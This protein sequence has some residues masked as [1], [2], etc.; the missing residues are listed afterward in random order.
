MYKLIR[1]LLFL[2]DAEAIHEFSTK[3]IKFFNLIP[4]SS[5]MMRKYYLVS[6][7]SLEREVFG[8]KFKNPVGLAAGFDKNAEYYDEFSN[9]GFGFIEIGTVTP[10]PQPGNPKKRIFRLVEN[11]SM[12]NRLGFNNK[13]LKEVA[14]NLK[15]ERDIIV[16][17]NIGKNS[18]TD[19]KEGYKD[20]LKC[21]SS[22]YDYV[23]Y[24]AVNI[25]SPN[26]KDLRKLHNKDLLKPLL[27][28]LVEYN[29]RQ[30]KK[31]PIL[32]KISPDLTNNQLN[33]IIS[34]I[35]DLEIDGV[36]ATNTSI[37]REGI[38]SVY[39]N[40]KGGLSGKLLNKKSNEIIRYL[41]ENLAKDFPIIGVGGIM[42]PEDAI[43]KINCGADLIQIYTGF[44]YQGPSLIKKINKLLLK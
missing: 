40:E 34:I 4:L 35:L 13:G 5:L 24:F 23:D 15:K 9:F 14:N 1:N 41:R 26:T 12:I 18:F 31:K 37:S 38:T 2:F 17:A 10:L 29:Q 28:K 27:Q 8:I 36:I 16:G 39:K 33:D 21:L 3:S 44:I 7:K 6:D 20:Y 42:S 30:N 25:S 43:E 22:L 32:L 19:N 11:K